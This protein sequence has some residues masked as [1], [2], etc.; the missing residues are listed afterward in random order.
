MDRRSE[1]LDTRSEG[2]EVRRSGGQKIQRTEGRMDRISRKSV[3]ARKAKLQPK[4]SI[5]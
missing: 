4:N 3:S 1:V 2:Q 5:L